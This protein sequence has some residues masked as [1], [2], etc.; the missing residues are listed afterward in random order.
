MVRALS[1]F[2]GARGFDRV[3]RWSGISV[4]LPAAK[5]SGALATLDTDGSGSIAYGHL[6]GVSSEGSLVAN[7]QVEALDISLEPRLV[8]LLRMPGS[9]SN[10]R[11]IV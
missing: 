3:A 4:G 10:I 11:A 5:D 8:L 7:W 9:R 1:L 2:S 6:D